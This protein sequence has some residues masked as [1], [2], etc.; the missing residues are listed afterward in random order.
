LIELNGASAGPN[1][2]GLVLA[3]GSGGSNILGL[4]INS[5]G[6]FSTTPSGTAANGILVQSNGNTIAG[7]F[8]GVDPTGTV[9]RPNGADGIHGET[10]SANVIG[11]PSPAI[12]NVVSGNSLDG[13]HVVGFLTAPATGNVI[14]GNFVGLAADGKSG[15]GPRTLPAPAPGTTQGNNLF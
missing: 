4:V 15:V 7:N 1:A 5:F 3:A 9:A 11:S 13:I 10:A 8:V 14:W 6:S 12:R 2:N